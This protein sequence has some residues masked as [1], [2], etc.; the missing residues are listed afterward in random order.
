[1]EYD[2]NIEQSKPQ[3]TAIGCKCQGALMRQI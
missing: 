3:D 1:M 2:A